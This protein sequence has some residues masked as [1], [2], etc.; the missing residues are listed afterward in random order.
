[1]AAS[2]AGKGGVGST[3]PPANAATS[4]LVPRPSY[5]KYGFLSSDPR[6]S[7]APATR[8]SARVVNARLKKWLNMLDP[9]HW[10]RF[11]ESAKLRARVR[12][13]IPDGVRGAAWQRL[14]RSAALPAQ[15]PGVFD[16]LVHAEARGESDEIIERD[17][18]RT[19]PSHLLFRGDAS[20]GQASLYNVLR[21]YAVYDENVG[22]CQ[23]MGFVAALF[24]MY[25]PDENAF[26]LLVQV[27]KKYGLDQMYAPGL[28]LLQVCLY[29]FDALFKEQLPALHA[30]FERENVPPSMISSQWFMTVMLY[31]LPFDAALRVWDSFIFDGT[32]IIFRVGLAM[33]K[34]QEKAFLATDF[35]GIMGIFGD[36]PRDKL[37]PDVLF[38]QAFAFSFTRA[39]LAEL[40]AD[41]HAQNAA[42]G[43]GS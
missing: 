23:G 17:I 19:F 1:M 25:M 27:M 22:Y 20:Q 13:G 40:E 32:K 6:A 36:Y 7:L 42:A 8:E 2:S 10:P 4:D 18:N 35:E 38:E 33:L 29:Q 24:L 11:A 15:F 5:D 41:F 9:R 3:L 26:W 43:G 16:S 14:A 28:P 12:K 34:L 39:R 31:S 37:E 30:H 21:A